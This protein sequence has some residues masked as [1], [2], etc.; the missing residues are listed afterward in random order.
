MFNEKDMFS[1]PVQIPKEGN[2]HLLK[3][4][5]AR[6]SPLR[7]ISLEDTQMEVIAEGIPFRFG[8]ISTSDG[9]EMSDSISVNMEGNSALRDLIGDM[10]L[11]DIRVDDN[12]V[13]GK[14]VSEV[15]IVSKMTRMNI[16][17]FSS[18]RHSVSPSH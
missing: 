18:H 13:I 2:L 6:Q 17:V 16:P 7:P 12:I 10:S 14:K 11:K 5:F 4:M 3:N 1:L 15:E 9:E 8:H